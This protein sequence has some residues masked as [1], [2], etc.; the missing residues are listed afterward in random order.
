[1]RLEVAGMGSIGSL[2]RV[3]LCLLLRSDTHSAG[4]LPDA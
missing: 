1:M 4:R 2:E 3:V